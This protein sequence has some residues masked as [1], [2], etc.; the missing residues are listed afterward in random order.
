M[1]TKTSS[2][3][4]MSAFTLIWVGQL[5]SLLSTGMVRFALTIWAWQE[6]GAATALAL[7][8]F[9]AFTPMILAT[10]IAGV[11]V[12]RWP[13][14][15]VMI[16]SDLGAG[17][18][19]VAILALYLTGSLEIWHLY[20][21]GAFAGIFESFQFPAYSAAVTTM[22][23]KKDYARASGMIGMAESASGIFAPV[24]AGLM[25]VVTGIG[26]ILIIDI[27]T[28]SIAIG[29]L[30]FVHIPQPKRTAAGEEGKGSIWTEAL[31]GFRYIFR[32]PSLF[33]L[34]M[35]FFGTNLVG[36]VGF[37]LLAPMILARTA[38][39][40]VVLGSV[41][42]ALGIGGFVGG[43]ILSTWGGPKRR[44]HGVLLGMI[45]SG[46]LGTALMGVGQSILIW[47]PAAFISMFS[48]QILN[49][50]NQALWQA[51]VDPDVQG[52]VFAV[53]RL[54]AQITAPVAMLMAGPLA[55][56]LFE[57]AMQTGGAWT[58]SFGWLVGIG[59]GAGMGLIFVIFGILNALVGLSGYLFP[60]I[61]RAEDLLPDHTD[62][63][64]IATNPT[65]DTIPD[66]PTSA[67]STV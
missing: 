13:R 15:L 42:S 20:I 55:D 32:R 60:V 6:T 57:P 12:D 26:G 39:N 36:T 47:V 37:T 14:K 61:R 64:T 3:T 28:F 16:L 49:A 58:S 24:L 23:D 38:D 5:I 63:A 2:P 44:V 11:L 22:L 7:V 56:R 34:Q 65:S 29:I 48:I 18:S 33:G 35:I 30:L 10:P 52:R 45:S 62:T 21:A 46:L 53:R 50:S 67:P 19:T 51:K 17:L 4:G 43:L 66:E 9:F 41:Q 54:I 8:G 31:Y 25:L 59:P 1:S 40:A 27:I